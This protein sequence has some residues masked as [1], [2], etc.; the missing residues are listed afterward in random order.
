MLQTKS[1]LIIVRPYVLLIS[2]RTCVNIIQEYVTSDPECWTNELG[3][4]F[5]RDRERT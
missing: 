4:V 2:A 5:T 3:Q 1:V